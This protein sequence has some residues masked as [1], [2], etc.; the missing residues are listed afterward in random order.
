MALGIKYMFN[1]LVV[2]GI[3]PSQFLES[4]NVVIQEKG[5]LVTLKLSIAQEV[6][7]GFLKIAITQPNISYS[8]WYPPLDDN[9]LLMVAGSVKDAGASFYVGLIKYK[10]VGDSIELGTIKLNAANGENIKK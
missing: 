7:S 3:D 5:I 6:D 10:P 4:S 8:D 1:T 9:G 2:V